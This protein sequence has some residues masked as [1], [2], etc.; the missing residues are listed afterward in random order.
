MIFFALSRERFFLRAFG[1]RAEAAK[2]EKNASIERGSEGRKTTIKLLISFLLFWARSMVFMLVS[3]YSGIVCVRVGRRR[4]IVQG[5][6]S[7]RGIGSRLFASI[8]R[9]LQI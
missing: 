7:R 6:N 5:N 9:R 4:T 2:H 1:A 8:R 3:F